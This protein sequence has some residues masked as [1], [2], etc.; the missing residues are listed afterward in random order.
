[1]E[2]IGC[3]NKVRDLGMAFLA[4][5]PMEYQIS[6]YKILLVVAEIFGSACLELSIKERITSSKGYNWPF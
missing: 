6:T 3:E 1:M 2:Y 5:T 4:T